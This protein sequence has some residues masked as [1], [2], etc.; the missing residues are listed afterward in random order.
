MHTEVELL[1]YGISSSIQQYLQF[2]IVMIFMFVCLFLLQILVKRYDIF[3]G[4]KPFV[5]NRNIDIKLI[6]TLEL[7]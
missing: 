3:V 4:K 1:V 5:L 2:H 7:C 6:I